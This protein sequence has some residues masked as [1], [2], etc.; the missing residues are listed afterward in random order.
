MFIGFRS[1]ACRETLKKETDM[2]IYWMILAL[3]IKHFLVDYPLQTPWI[4][5]NKREPTSIGMLVH[6]ALHGIGTW[7]CMN[8]FYGFLDFIFHSCID[9]LKVLLQEIFDLKPD[10]KYFWWLFGVDQLIHQLFYLWFIHLY[11]MK[12]IQ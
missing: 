9:S 10:S 11:F 8:L 4:L 2:K 5:K 6:G 3:Q 12:G 1:Y 7:L